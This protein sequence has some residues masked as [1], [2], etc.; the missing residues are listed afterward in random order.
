MGFLE[1]EDH[2]SLARQLTGTYENR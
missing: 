2:L 1:I